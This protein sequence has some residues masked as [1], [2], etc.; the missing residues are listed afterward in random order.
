MHDN[1]LCVFDTPAPCSS[2][3]SRNLESVDHPE[4]RK[5]LFLDCYSVLRLVGL[6]HT[7]VAEIS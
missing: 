4:A 5:N 1:I 6:H 7:Y 3:L 2:A